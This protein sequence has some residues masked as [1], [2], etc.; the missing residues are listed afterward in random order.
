MIERFV[1]PARQVFG[2]DGALA[3]ELLQAFE[4]CHGGNSGEDVGNGQNKKRRA[5]SPA[6]RKIKSSIEV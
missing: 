4:V 5:K 1:D 3:A 6:P 2:D